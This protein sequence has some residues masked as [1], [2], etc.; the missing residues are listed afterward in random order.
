MTMP[1]DYPDTFNKPSNETERQ[2]EPHTAEPDESQPTGAQS[3][4][5]EQQVTLAQAIVKQRQAQQGG[6]S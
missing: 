4:G 1:G 5:E 2:V 3:V 6:A